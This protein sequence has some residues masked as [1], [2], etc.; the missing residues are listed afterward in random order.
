[1]AVPIVNTTCLVSAPST[2]TPTRPHTLT[3]KRC[4]V[5][6]LVGWLQTP[7]KDRSKMA[8]LL[9][10]KFEI[11][12]YFVGS[13]SVLS[14]YS[15]GRTSGVVVDIGCVLDPHHPPRLVLIPFRPAMHVCK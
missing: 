7:D 2:P 11:P 9:F 13:Q 6:W 1:M 15:A 14:L 12:A 4:S 10:E 5:G 3:G 8:E